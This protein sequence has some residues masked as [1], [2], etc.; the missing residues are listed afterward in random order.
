[1]NILLNKRSPQSVGSNI[2]VDID[3]DDII[4]YKVLIGNLG[5]WSTIKEFNESGQGLWVP[6]EPGEYMIM[7]QGKK[8]NS[9]KPFDLLAKEEFEIFAKEEECKL[10]KDII[11]EKKEFIEGEKIN[12]KVITDEKEVL[13]RFSKKINDEWEVVRDY[14]GEDTISYSA[15]GNGEEEVLVECKKIDSAKNVDDFKTLKFNIKEKNKGEITDFKCLTESLL[16][17]E[18]LVFKVFANLDET[19]PLLFKFIK[20]DEDGRSTVVQDFSSRRVVSFSETTEGR[21][22]LLCYMRDIFSNKEFDD[23]A[24][25]VYDVSLYEPIKIRSFSA[26]LKSPQV[27]GSKIN[28]KVNAEGGRELVYRY[29]VDGPISDD[30]CYTRNSEF[31]WET[32]KEGEYRITVYAKDASFNGDFEVKKTILFDIDKK[33]AKP[34]RIVDVIGDQKGE[35]LIGKPVNV[36]IIAEGGTYLSYSFTILNNGVELERIDFNEANWINFTPKEKGDYEVRVEVKD[37]YS[38]ESYDASMS[39]FVKA[40]DYL[41]AKIEHILFPHKSIYLIG[42]PIEIEAIVKQTKNVL[43]NYI[44]KINGHVVEETGYITNKKLKFVPKVSGK[45]TFEVFSKHIRCQEEFDSR[46]ELSFYVHEATPVTDTKISIDKKVIEIGKEVT[47]KVSSNGGKDVCYEFYIM[48]KGNWIKAQSYSKKK[49]YTFMPFSKGYYRM[50]V[51]S[52]SYYK[53]VNYEDY[54]EIEFEV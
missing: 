48:E 23:R 45:Y 26:D 51:L 20:I 12:I 8:R 10:I 32:S 22:K 31:T 17:N 27:S 39:Y 33:A 1:M 49:Y 34:V 46:K 29:I 15:H 4:D 11:V 16:V 25:M 37:K 21:Y 14:S 13:F 6:E 18:E 54:S 28:F 2:K 7:V 52:K 9:N 53:R 41:P 44:T 35:V 3:C 38:K 5:L 42:D 40:R 30:S 19:R 50:I 47:F 43:I 36:K 24:L